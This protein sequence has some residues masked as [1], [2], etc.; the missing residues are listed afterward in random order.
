VSERSG[1][2]KVSGYTRQEASKQASKKSSTGN[3]LGKSLEKEASKPNYH[4]TSRKLLSN[5]SNSQ[6]NHL[7]LTSLE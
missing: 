1:G 6:L 2:K 4:E 5:Y 7:S 3:V